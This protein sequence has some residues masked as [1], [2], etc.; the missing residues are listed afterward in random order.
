MKM[1]IYLII[2]ILYSSLQAQSIILNE[3]MS[4]NSNM[5]QDEDGEYSDWIEIF[6]PNEITISLFNYSLSDDETYLRKWL[7]PETS[8]LPGEYL[9]VFASNKDRLG[10]E[11]HT[12]FRISSE[13]ETIILANHNGFV[14]DQLGAIPIPTNI[15]YGRN[16]NDNTSDWL[17][18][19]SPTPRSKNSSDGYFA[20]SEYP[21]FSITGGF[22]TNSISLDL[23]ASSTATEIYYTIDGSN[24]TIHSNKYEPYSP[25]VI[26]KTAVIRAKSFTDNYIPSKIITNTY[27]INENFTL[28]VVSLST[29]PNNFW[30][31]EIGIYVVGSNGILG[32]CA[33]EIANYNQEWERPVH[34]EF[35]EQDGARGFGI[36]AGIAIHGG[37][38]RN[39]PQ[40]SLKII[41]RG[42][43]GSNT[44]PYKIFPNLPYDEYASILLRSSGNDNSSTLMRDG[45]MQTLV[46]DLDMETEAYRPSI[47]FLNGKY[48][49]IHNIRE[50]HHKDYIYQHHPQANA[51]IDLLVKTH[52]VKE[53]SSDHYDN[54]YDFIESSDLSIQENYEYVE[55]QM[56]IKNYTNYLLSEMY[57]VNRDW[58]PNNTKFWRPRTNE[59]RWRWILY[60]TDYG[61]GI[62]N[63]ET[64]NYNMINWVKSLERYP[65]VIINGLLENQIFVTDFINT[66]ADLSNTVFK[67]TNVV[68]RIDSYATLIYDEMPAQIEKWG[69]ISS[70]TKWLN[71]IDDLKYFANNRIQ[72]MQQHFIDEFNLTGIAPLNLNINNS[73]AGNVQINSIM[74]DSSYWF[75]NYFQGIEIT[76]EA[77]PIEGYEFSGWTGDTI[78]STKKIKY[79]LNKENN[80]TATFSAIEAPELIP[81]IVINEINYNSNP[82]IDPGDWIELYNNS[83]ESIDISNWIIKDDNDAHIFTIPKNNLISKGNY[84]IICND[85]VAFSN[86]FPSVQKVIGNLGFGFS[87]SGELLRLY[88]HSLTLVDSVSY[89]DVDPWPVEP[90]GNGPTLE[91]KHPNLDN[92]VGTSWISSNSNGTP[93]AINSFSQN[94]IFLNVSSDTLFASSDSTKLQ[95]II[96]SNN[97][98]KINNHTNWLLANPD[99][100]F[101][102]TNINVFVSSNKDSL[103]RFGIIQ[104]ESGNISKQLVIIND[105]LDV[106]K[107]FASTDSSISGNILGSGKYLKGTIVRLVANPNTGWKFLNWSENDSIVSYDSIYVF[108]AMS[109]R[110]LIAHFQDITT[111]IESITIFPS[112]FE[113][114]QN[115]PN[116]FNQST[117]IKY[118]IPYAENRNSIL[119][120]L[121]IYNVLGNEISMLVNNYKAPGNYEVIFNASNVASGIYYYQILTDKFMQTKKMTLLK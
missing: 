78:S 71:N 77:V 104:I 27:F 46:E 54:M 66:F 19:P 100:G 5:I 9:I 109:N 85:L 3:I 114:S 95:V 121:K 10:A 36:D 59:G 91:L 22:Y 115:Y 48:F 51:N 90:D 16:N 116:P 107:I 120:S 101:G 82:T 40:K 53:G 62:F 96:E 25:I 67:P 84:L 18:F 92:S 1:I 21:V 23:T 12:N 112:N 108:E 6:N 86:V 87:G 102:D 43:Y 4:S 24:P 38:T 39:R 26:N 75:G 42:E 69:T 94:G 117:V 106:F 110:N 81:Q 34:V 118:A 11:L 80:I 99:S 70:I 35:F 41:A 83:D 63:L 45:L 14:I 7:F 105:G 49:G 32:E 97:F 2:M 15:S 119:V 74:I 60:D 79:M 37:C 111:D 8:I 64:I 61:F 28:P 93:G 98:W 103:K 68:A 113:L 73:S 13:G 31:D 89:D 56:E 57:F 17:F 29:N 47:V 55:T 72:I 33:T 65:S 58:Y 88:H 76:L 20:V 30:D 52:Y 44:I 50:R